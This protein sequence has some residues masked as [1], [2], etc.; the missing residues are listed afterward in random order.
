MA[1]ERGIYKSSSFKIEYYKKG[2]IGV[3]DFNAL[4]VF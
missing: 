1:L 4:Y 2:C 3:K